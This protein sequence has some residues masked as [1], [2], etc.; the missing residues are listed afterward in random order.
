MKANSAFRRGFSLVELLVVMAIIAILCALMSAGI[1][2]M[3]ATPPQRSTELLIQK[4]AASLEQQWTATITQVKTEN[5]NT[6]LWGQ[7]QT[8]AGANAQPQQIM[9]QYTNLRL[10]QEFPTSFAQVQQ[11]VANGTAKAIYQGLPAAPAPTAQGNSF[12]SG[13]LL[14]IALTVGRRGMNF[15]S[16]NLSPKEARPIPGASGDTKALYDGWD[17][18]IQFTTSIDQVTG[19]LTFSIISAGADKKLGTP[20]DVNSNTLRL[21]R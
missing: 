5:I 13:I 15:D 11:Q 4:L 16:G 12:E 8:L 2:R 7:A 14:Y 1:M 6:T 10:Q 17:Q 9:A 19:S 18:P 3:M 21:G 20:D